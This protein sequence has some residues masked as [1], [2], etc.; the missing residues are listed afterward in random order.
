[1][2]FNELFELGN[3]NLSFELDPEAWD[4]IHLA[5]RRLIQLAKQDIIKIYGLH[6]HYGFH[7]KLDQDPTDF[8]G[9]QTL[10]LN[11]LKVGA[12]QALPETVVRRAL[13]IQCLKSAY[14]KSGVHPEIVKEMLRLASSDDLPVVP[15]IGSL[16]ASGDLVPMAH[17]IAPVIEKMGIRGPRDVIGNVNTN[18]MMASYAIELTI[19]LEKKLDL[20]KQGLPY[21]LTAVRAPLQ[22]FDPRLFSSRRPNERT[23]V[24]FKDLWDKLGEIESSKNSHMK[25]DSSFMLQHR[26]S[27]RVV[28][29]LLDSLH[30][31]LDFAKE[32]ILEEALAVADNPIIENENEVLH[33]GLFYTSSLAVAVDLLTDIE[34]KLCELL[35]RQVLNLMDAELSGGLP[36]N[37]WFEADKLHAKGLHQLGSATL[38]RVKALCLPTR[39]MSFSCESNNQDLV[40][41]TMTG[42]NQLHELSRH[43]DLLLKI[44]SFCSMRAFY[45]RR[46]ADLPLKLRV[47]QWDQYKISDFKNLLNQQ[48][49]TNNHQQRGNYEFRAA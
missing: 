39:Q 31:Q 4:R 6:T 11:Y 29:Q 38:Q 46:G 48:Q 27:F 21:L 30:K 7:V 10:L 2:H 36:D 34:V 28:P 18:A 49:P 16:G 15:S 20:F 32:L 45:I 24:F 41:C 22:A 23:V 40:P 17:A 35:D 26:Y 1:M 44:W 19:E 5:H 25:H 14:G 9:H 43:F 33:G 47:D 3:Q 12:G 8:V 13:R 37:L 42:C